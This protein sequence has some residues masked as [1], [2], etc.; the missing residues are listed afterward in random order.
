ML[1]LVLRPSAKINLALRVGP[2]RPDG[3]HDVRTVL[4]SIALHDVLTI[5]ASRGPLVLTTNAP[6]VPADETNL[7]WRAAQALWTAMRR[8]GEPRHARVAIDKRIPVGAGLGGGSA[9]AAAALVGLHRLWKGRL[10]PGDLLR[11]GASI[12]ADVPFFLVGGTALG[13]DRGDVIYPLIDAARLG[14]VI[15][16]PNFSVSTADAYRWFDEGADED[17][18][19]TTIGAARVGWPTGPLAIANDLQAP[20]AARHPVIADMVWACRAAGAE[21]A[22]MTGSGSAVFGLFDQAA[23]SQAAQDLARRSEGWRVFAT[24]TLLRR[25]ACRRIGL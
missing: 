24:R 1:N 5:Q 15:I 2:R 6:D 13:V 12:G 8:N 16:R 17:R 18:G 19:A 3:Y 25:D 7:V 14:V 20:V 22:G 10:T 21:A 23:V 11:I 4:Q 9:D